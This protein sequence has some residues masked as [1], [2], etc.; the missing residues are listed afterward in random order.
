MVVRQIV[1]A[2]GT[3]DDEWADIFRDLVYR[4]DR[5]ERART[6][7]EDGT[8]FAAQQI[9][10]TV[11]LIEDPVRG[12]PLDE[13]AAFARF[14]AKLETMASPYPVYAA[15]MRAQIAGENKPWETVQ[16]RLGLT[17]E[18]LHALGLGLPDDL[19]AVEI[20]VE[21]SGTTVIVEP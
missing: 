11:E 8:R 12:E 18:E 3:P 10:L 9:K 19:D 5:V 6:S 13:D 7:G 14:L 1:D 17:R 21:G 20:A 2:L 4:V 15:M 16:R